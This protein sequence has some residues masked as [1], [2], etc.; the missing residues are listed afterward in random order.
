MAAVRSQPNISGTGKGYGKQASEEQAVGFGAHSGV[1]V[2]GL[3]LHNED[4]GD[5]T[6]H[7]GNGPI[8]GDE[9]YQHVAADAGGGVY[10][11]ITSVRRILSAMTMNAMTT[12]ATTTTTTTT[13]TT[14]SAKIPRTLPVRR[15]DRREASA[16]G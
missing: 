8:D 4:P 9:G 14:T 11:E 16:S 12:T 5:R 6:A 13:V 1:D 3:I 15:L 10:A 2:D 7:T